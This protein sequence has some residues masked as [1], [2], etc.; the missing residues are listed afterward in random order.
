MKGGAFYSTLESAIEALKN[1]GTTASHIRK[2]PIDEKDGN[3]N[4]I[5]F[6]YYL[7]NDVNLNRYENSEQVYPEV[8]G[9]R[10]SRKLKRTIMKKKKRR[11]SNRRNRR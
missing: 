9:R 1:S 11:K 2:V 7:N 4:E 3:G 8:G 5:S 10:K 6:R